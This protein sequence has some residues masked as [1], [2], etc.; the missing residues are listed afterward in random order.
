MSKMKKFLRGLWKLAG[1]YKYLI[2]VVLGLLWIC[3]LDENSWRERMR[4][5]SEINALQDE[6]KQMAKANE[7][8]SLLLDKLRHDPKAYER[9]ARERYFMKALDEDI[10]VL[11][12][13]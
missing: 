12:D 5:Q 6:Y 3:L 11:S 2:T 7:R 8:D 1:R 13:E 4:L 10:F 9:I